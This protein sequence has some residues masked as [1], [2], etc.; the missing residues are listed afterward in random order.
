MAQPSDTHKDC[1][2][3]LRDPTA[4]TTGNDQERPRMWLE[5]V[6]FYWQD[7]WQ[8]YILFVPYFNLTFN[9]CHLRFFT[10]PY[11]PFPPFYLLYRTLRVAFIHF[12]YYTFRLCLNRPWQLRYIP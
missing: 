2:N 6:T 12:I 8:H 3:T 9:L 7:Q 4:T 1:D 5:D 11:L 10:F